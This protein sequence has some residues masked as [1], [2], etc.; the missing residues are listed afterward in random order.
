MNNK[1]NSKADPVVPFP[2]ADPVVPFHKAIAAA[3]DALETKHDTG[4]AKTHSTP[5][6][7]IDCAGAALRAS[8]SRS[9]RDYAP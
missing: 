6:L 7:A 2:K 8:R 4:T 3:L 1:R 9:H 5:S